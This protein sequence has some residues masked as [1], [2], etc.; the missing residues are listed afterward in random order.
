LP[1]A[2]YELPLALA[3]GEDETREKGFSRNQKINIPF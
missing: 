2:F 3:S 1:T